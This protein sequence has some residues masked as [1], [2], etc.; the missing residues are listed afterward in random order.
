MAFEFRSLIAVN[1][2]MI[3]N[4]YAAWAFIT[5]SRPS[6]DLSASSKYPANG[7]WPCWLDSAGIVLMQRYLHVQLYSY[8]YGG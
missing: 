7:I 4:L 1:S 8:R 3:D 6:E 5:C 2:V